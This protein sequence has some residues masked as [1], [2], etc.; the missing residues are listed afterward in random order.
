MGGLD[1]RRSLV[2]D[3][4]VR[5]PQEAGIAHLTITFPD[6]LTINEFDV[7]TGANLSTDATSYAVITHREISGALGERFDS[8]RVYQDPIRLT[9]Q[10]LVSGLCG[11]LLD[12]A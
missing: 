6:G 2:G 7:F 12:T 8:S 1:G 4:F 10:L 11:T 9:G 5:T 3:R